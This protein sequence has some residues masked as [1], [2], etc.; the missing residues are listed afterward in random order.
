MF[1]VLLAFSDDDLCQFFGLRELVISN[2]RAI[3]SCL[4]TIMRTIHKRGDIFINR[5]DRNNFRL[6]IVMVVS[7]RKTVLATTWVF[8]PE[9]GL[10][11]LLDDVLY[12]ILV[13]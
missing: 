7:P 11:Q 12:T 8:I 4:S 2:Y 9:V 3:W 1:A 5:T 13:Q 10:L 6:F